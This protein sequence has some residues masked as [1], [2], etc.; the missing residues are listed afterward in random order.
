[1][2]REEALRR[3]FVREARIG[4]ALIGVTL[5]VFVIVA[6]YKM[7]GRFSSTME[8]VTEGANVTASTLNPPSQRAHAE[9]A[10]VAAIQA[11]TRS[12]VGQVE[13]HRGDTSPTQSPPM[14]I[15]KVFNGDP[16]PSTE[17]PEKKSEPADDSSAQISGGE[18]DKKMS[19]IAPEPVAA[20]LRSVA[21]TPQITSAK[22]DQGDYYAALAGKTDALFPVAA[23]SQP[24][25]RKVNA[26]EPISVLN[27]PLPNT[28]ADIKSSTSNAELSISSQRNATPVTS[29]HA[30]DEKVIRLAAGDSLW[31]V[32]QRHYGDGRIFRALAAYNGLDKATSTQQTTGNE[33]RLPRLEQLLADFPGLMPMDSAVSDSSNSAGEDQSALAKTYVTGVDETLFGIARDQLGQAY[34]YVEIIEINAK[35]LPAD[36]T[37]STKLAAGTRLILTRK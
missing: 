23:E 29:P 8:S 24:P 5:G 36:V 18:P 14:P 21:A 15:P 7:S 25:I 31:A 30:A 28:F 33:I 13:P 4:V 16:I 22:S 6:Y 17:F 2:D 34:R 9:G 12:V 19:P 10:T 37:S 26:N 32:A 11:A 1:M 35:Q 3:Q 20:K 27:R